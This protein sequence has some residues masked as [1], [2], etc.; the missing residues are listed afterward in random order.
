MKNWK[1]LNAYPYK[2]ARYLVFKWP[3]NLLAPKTP[4]SGLFMSDKWKK[5]WDGQI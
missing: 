2:T 1:I 5:F 4:F 3:K